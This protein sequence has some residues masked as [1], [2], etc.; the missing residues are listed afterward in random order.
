MH[1]PRR[2]STGHRRARAPPSAGGC[3]RSTPPARSS[4]RLDPVFHPERQ[5]SDELGLVLGVAV[6]EVAGVDGGGC[7]P[8]GR[9]ASWPRS[10]PQGFSAARRVG[11]PEV[12]SGHTCLRC[13]PAIA[14]APFPTVSRT[15]CGASV[16]AEDPHLALP[17]RSCV[18]RTRHWPRQPRP[19]APARVGRAR[20]AECLDVAGDLPADPTAITTAD[21]VA[22]REHLAGWD[23][24]L[25]GLLAD[26]R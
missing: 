12:R 11:R 1:P 23:G 3:R 24:D 22:M 16:P 9:S 13:I 6:A 5:A 20:R 4:G 21:V 17:R 25:R 14:S 7:P 18:R 26:G 15:A 8:T 2:G 10:Y 19:G